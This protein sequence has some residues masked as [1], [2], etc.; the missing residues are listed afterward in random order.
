MYIGILDVRRGGCSRRALAL[1]SQQ[2]RN[3]RAGNRLL[4]RIILAAAPRTG[5]TN[6]LC[7]TASACIGERLLF[8]F[9]WL[10]DAGVQAYLQ[11]VKDSVKFTLSHFVDRRSS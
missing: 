7:Q 8:S 6:G 9:R 2:T 4:H 3:L 5:P 11:G 10:A 1:T